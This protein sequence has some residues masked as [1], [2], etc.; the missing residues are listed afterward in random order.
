MKARMVEWVGGIK[1]L[2]MWFKSGQDSDISWEQIKELF[3]TGNNVML[4]HSGNDIVIFVDNK[5]FTQR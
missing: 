1:N 3:D 2:P 5:R 4:S